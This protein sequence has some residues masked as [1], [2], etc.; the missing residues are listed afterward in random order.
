MSITTIEKPVVKPE[1]PE[2][3]S[4]SYCREY[5]VHTDTMRVGTLYTYQGGRCV[6]ATCMGGHIPVCFEFNKES[7]TFSDLESQFS[8]VKKGGK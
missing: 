4:G 5:D 2:M 7:R 6:F 1:F 3:G 8:F